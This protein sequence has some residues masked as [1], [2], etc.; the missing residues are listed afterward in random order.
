MGRAEAFKM[1]PESEPK[2]TSLFFTTKKKRMLERK[3]K[4]KNGFAHPLAVLKEDRLL[5]VLSDVGLQLLVSP[6]TI[7][8][9][10]VLKDQQPRVLSCL[11]GFHQSGVRSDGLSQLLQSTRTTS[12]IPN[13]N[14]N[15]GWAT[16]I[17]K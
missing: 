12:A 1:R 3:G 16:Q 5:D 8:G 10:G 15:Q 4:E 2:N 14:P 9:V 11:L 17:S 13:R 6:G 7:R